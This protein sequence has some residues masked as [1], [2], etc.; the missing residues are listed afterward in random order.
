[1]PYAPTVTPAIYP[2]GKIPPNEAKRLGVKKDERINGLSR[3]NY[4]LHSNN[5]TLKENHPALRAL[6]RWRGI[7]LD[8]REFAGYL[9]LSST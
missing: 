1:M 2:Y 8:K 3:I 7:M 9:T 5:Y 6:L 4:T